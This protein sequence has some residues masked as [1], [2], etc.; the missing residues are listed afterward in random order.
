[1]ITEARRSLVLAPKLYLYKCAA[2]TDSTV[3]RQPVR[4]PVCVFVVAGVRRI[5]R[6]THR[7][8]LISLM[9]RGCFFIII[10]DSKR[11]DRVALGKRNA[12]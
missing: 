1:M 11:E 2:Q 5:D 8:H 12:R 4:R 6:R 10:P 9:H 3:P 7:L